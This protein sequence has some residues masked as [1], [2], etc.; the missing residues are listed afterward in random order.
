MHCSVWQSMAM[1]ETRT[2]IAGNV[3]AELARAGLSQRELARRLN[4]PS[5]QI[6]VR[7]TGQVPFTA[8]E[9]IAIAAALDI[10]PA[11]LL[12]VNTAA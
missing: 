1:T 11:T 3:R 6:H 5:Q 4:R 9:L 12:A 7:M 10:P 2:A 8:E